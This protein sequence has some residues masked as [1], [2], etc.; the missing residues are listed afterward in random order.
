[1]PFL[2]GFFDRETFRDSELVQVDSARG[3]FVHHFRNGQRMVEKIFAGLQFI[4]R[5]CIEDVSQSDVT[6]AD[7]LL[8]LEKSNDSTCTQAVGNFQNET[9]TWSS[10]ALSRGKRAGDAEF[11]TNIIGQAGHNECGEK[12]AK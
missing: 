7:D 9:L 10:A 1:M 2:G 6:I 11:F 5:S 4:S 12:S 3:E 8:I